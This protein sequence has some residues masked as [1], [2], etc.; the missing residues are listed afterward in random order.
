[1]NAG[2]AFTK[3]SYGGET[4]NRIPL[5]VAL[6]TT[7]SMQFLAG[8]H[9]LAQ[10]SEEAVADRTIIVTA[11]RIEE[12]LQDVPISIA[13]VNQE[14]LN[15][16]NIVGVDDLVKLVP[17]LNVESRY[18]SETN[19]FS[20]RGFSQALRTTSSVGTFFSEVVAPRGGAGAF[21]GGDGAGPGSLFDLQNVQVLKGPQG[22]LFGRNTTG[23]SVLL[24]PRKPTSRFEGYVEGSIGNRD[25]RRLQAVV[26]LPLADWA[27][28]RLGVDRQLRD[29]TLNNVSGIG[30]KKFNDVNYTALRGSLVLDVT[31]NLENYT[32]VSYLNSNHIGTQPQLYRGNPNTTF[33]TFALPQIARL[34]ANGDPYQVEQTLRNPRSITKQFQAI[35]ITKWTASDNLTIKNILSYATF[36]QG[37]RQSVF[38]FNFPRTVVPGIVS[39]FPSPMAFNEAGT[40]GND[41]KTF[42]EELQVQ[43]KAFDGRLDF[44]GGLYYEHSTPGDPTSSESIAVGAICQDV[45]FEGLASMRCFRLNPVNTVN[46]SVYRIEFINMAAYA[47]ATYAATDQLKLTAGIRLNYDRTR[48][49]SQG[50]LY[51]FQL[52]PAN[53]AALFVPA[54]PAGV[55][56]AACQITHAPFPNCTVGSDLLRTSSKR[57]TWTLNAAYTP[58]DDVMLYAT[59]ARGYRQGAAAPAAIGA[60]STFDPETVDNFEL[61]AKTSFAGSVPGHF[62]LAGFYSK[63]RD[64]QLLIGVQC[65]RTVPVPPATVNCP[66][67]N[68]ATSVFNAGRAHIYGVE[69]DGSLRL[70]DFFRLNAS[71]AYVKSRLDALDVDIT[72]YSA[73]FDNILFPAAVGDPLPLT[74]EFGGNVSG[75]ITLPI[76]ESAGKLEFSGTYRY[77]SSFSTA[78]SNTNTVAA[79]GLRQATPTAACPAACVAARADL[80]AGTPVDKASAVSQLDLNLD[81]RDVGGQ[82]VDLSLFVSN[83]TNQVTYTLIQPLFASFGFDLRYLGQ[84][85]MYG[86]RLRIRFGEGN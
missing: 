26:N 69:F 44:Q 50:L 76:P 64:A 39:N 40:Y 75:T 65:T 23:G 60:K 77:A 28:L 86:M 79:A 72:P 34:V 80:V 1:M 24:T 62:N 22:T 9:A 67:G 32:I 84:P 30:P 8:G 31:P 74:P 82:P 38:G 68:S 19:A 21:P 54:T 14:Q 58:L 66:A 61:G 56:A 45:A 48:G 53:P 43:G 57:P 10:S 2:R 51:R 11:R 27:R 36:K 52:D 5:R 35:N 3:N 37:L 78:A 59:Y 70:T 18:S 33:G 47:Q 41:Q 13:V 49:T 46:V 42:V 71:G 25:M 85:R 12:R 17:G 83:V 81:W 15:K 6:F 55:G 20:I 63:L 73:N 4:M 7:V 29:G 16:A